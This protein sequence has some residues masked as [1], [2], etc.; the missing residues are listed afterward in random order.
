MTTAARR[1]IDD[2]YPICRSITG[3]G[4][5]AT[6]DRIGEEIGLDRSGVA[7]GTQVFDWTIPDEWNIVDA[8]VTRAGSDERIIDFRRSNLH[9]VGYS[10]PVDRVM[11]LDELRPHL[12]SLPD[13]PALVPYRTSY[14]QR[15]W[16]FCLSHEQLESLEDGDYHVVIDST[17]ASGRL[18][19]AE[20]VVPGETSDTIVLSTHICHPS[21]CNDNLT[22]IAV[23]TEVARRLAATP[24]RFT[25]RLL[26]IPATIGSLAWLAGNGDVVPRIRHGLVL[27]GLG[28]ASP[29][30]YKRSRRGDATIDR[31]VD[32][33]MRDR[34]D[35]GRSIPFSPYGY[36][37]RQFC[38]PGFDL[39]F[40]RLT[41][42]VHGEYPEYHTSADDLS[43]VDD[44]QL[45]RAV[46]LTLAI[47]HGLEVNR[48]HRNLSP[49]GE[50]QLGR[51]GL[52]SPM[53][54]G[55]DQRSV[56]MGYLWVLNLSDGSHDLCDIAEASGLPIAALA[57]A[58]ERLVEVG[59]LAVGDDRAHG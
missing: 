31:I 54:G 11:S 58:A 16:G 13:R 33:V 53:G 19:W 32:V 28:D 29:F 14:Y 39:P 24:H 41:R 57:L 50:P 7:S 15:T 43:F 45:E 56:E 42:G 5:R 36:D 40:G 27:T 23:L 8:Y 46:E 22:G 20:H 48:V 52:Y 3:A 10:E 49:F 47:L 1:L 35:E 25:Y 55:I 18:E 59:L 9:V 30:T 38:S 4:V 44:T 26:F 6:L 34:G 12:H 51:R 2:L 21:L 17:L 37:E